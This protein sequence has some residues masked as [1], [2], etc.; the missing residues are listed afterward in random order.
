[1]RRTKKITATDF[2]PEELQK[3]SPAVLALQL[4]VEYSLEIF[5]AEKCSTKLVHG[6][7]S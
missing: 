5:F 2:A 6:A 4:I 7:K 1:M 3:G